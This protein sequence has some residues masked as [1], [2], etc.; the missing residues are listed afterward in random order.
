MPLKGTILVVDDNRGILT[1]LKLLLSRYFS[2]II[3]IPTP[4][5]IPAKIREHTVDAVLLDMN[6]QAGINNGNEGLFWL[7]EILRLKP[8][9]PVLMITAYGEIELAVTAVREGAADFILKPWNN[10]R[11][12][13]RL[14]QAI[15]LRRTGPRKS[16]AADHPDG[17]GM[18]W[19]TSRE[20]I[21]LKNLTE[22]ISR[23]DADVLI[24]GENGTGK[25]MLAREV[26]RLSGRRQ[27]NFVTVD[28][29][30]IPE[31]LFESELF[32]HVKGAFTDAR[33]DRPGKFRSADR[34]TLFLDE[35]GNLPLHL[36]AKLLVAL[37]T[38]RI[39][40]VGGDISAPLDIRLISAT[41]KNLD[42]MVD[43]QQFREDLLFR[44]N[45]IRLH[46]P[47]LRERRED[48][49]PLAEVFLRR[50]AAKYGKK[51]DG[52]SA[53]TQEKLRNYAWY[54]NIRELSHAVE[55]AVILS[56]G[57][58]LEPELFN[59]SV[60]TIR[61]ESVK[62]VRTLEEMEYLMIVNAIEKHNGNLS[63]VAAQLGITRQTLYNKLKKYD[64]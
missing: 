61:S 59:L 29:G 21:L 35:I 18:F 43:K 56:D 64:L 41:N 30:S 53:R 9:M 5:Q 22:K 54:G 28:M 12:V 1:A 3:A 8:G 49:L 57:R 63:A 37:Q 17:E 45:T 26:H 60:K 50:F 48:I 36:Q 39:V 25:E 14:T 31:S 7:R 10:E 33:T 24:T 40:P 19:G 6:F 44:I 42:E 38:R 13:E 55:R 62:N 4:N 34:G 47:P 16:P 20:M 32:G 46:L 58:M 23:T 27:Q 11:L 2:E 51:V 52:F 15:E